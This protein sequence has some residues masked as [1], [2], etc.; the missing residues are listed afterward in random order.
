[1]RNITELEYCI[2]YKSREIQHKKELLIKGK[3]IISCQLS[4]MQTPDN[5]KYLNNV[6][7]ALK[8]AEKIIET[9][10]FRFKN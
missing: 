9:L 8:S 6:M 10:T 4:L 1:M 2:K 5:Y 7:L 3:N